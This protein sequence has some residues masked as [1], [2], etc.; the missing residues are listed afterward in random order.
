MNEMIMNP[1]MPVPAQEALTAEP[2]QP[3]LEVVV[4]EMLNKAE[5][6]V[7][8]ISEYVDKPY[9]GQL[10]RM[11]IVPYREEDIAA[12]ADAVWLFRVTNLAFERDKNDFGRKLGN[13][14]S[15]VGMCGGT[16]VMRIDYTQE[17]TVLQIG[18]V[19]KKHETSITT[20]KDALYSSFRSN[21]HGSNLVEVGYDQVCGM[22]KGCEENSYS[23]NSVTSISVMPRRTDKGDMLNGLESILNAAGEQP[24]SILVIG[25]PMDAG[26]KLALKETYEQ[27]ATQ[28]SR[29]ISLS[30]TQQEGSGVSDGVN[31]NLSNAYMH[32]RNITLNVTDSENSSHTESATD[33][34]N[35]NKS[36]RISDKLFSA[37]SLLS[38][39]DGD[40]M[41]V[42]ALNSLKQMTRTQPDRFTDRSSSDTAGTGH[43]VGQGLGET[44]GETLT[45]QQGLSR[46]LT[47]N[48]GYSAQ[49]SVVNHKAKGLYDRVVKYL[50]WLDSSENYGMFNVS[51]YVL[52]SNA[53]TNM[54]IASQ[55]ASM[56]N[57]ENIA[58][59]YGIN[60]WSG[61]ES[62]A[63]RRYLSVFRHPVFSHGDLG[64]VS[65]GVPVSGA[66]LAQSFLLPQKSI[67]SLSVLQYEPFGRNVV[68]T[69]ASGARRAINL[70][71]IHHMG[72][73]IPF[74]PVMLDLETLSRHM[75][76]GGSNGIGKTT[77]ILSMLTKTMKQGIPF[78]VI[79]PAKGEY[80]RVFA[81]DK[82][83]K[84][85][86]LM[87]QKGTRPLRLN[88]FWFREGIDI[89]EHIV[90]LVEV[91]CSCWPMY[92]A[93][94]Q[95][96]QAAIGSAYRACGW[97]LEDSENPNGHIFPNIGDVCREVNSLI[98]QSDFSGE[99]KGNYK[100]SLVTRLKSLDDTVF[101]RIFSC[102]DVGDEELFENNVIIDIS[103]PDSE[104]VKSLIMGLLIVR[105]FEYCAAEK[106]FG[107]TLKHL[108]VL[109]EAHT[110][111]AP[112]PASS[113]GANMGNKAIEMMSRCIAELGGFGQGFII[114]DQAPGLLDRSVIRNTNTKMTFRLL[115]LDDCQLTGK[116][117]GLKDAQCAELARLGRGVCAVHQTGWEEAVLCHVR[118]EL[119][120]K[121][122]DCAGPEEE[123]AAAPTVSDYLTCLL[124]PFSVIGQT[125]AV[126]ADEH[127]AAFDWAAEAGMSAADRLTLIQAIDRA[128]LS[129]RRTVDAVGLLGIA[130]YQGE[131]GDLARWT[132]EALEEMK[133]YLTDRKLALTLIEALLDVEQRKSHDF[134]DF[135]DRWFDAV[136]HERT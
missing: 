1:E 132:E 84:S 81:D 32:S 88:P 62:L 61:E 45:L 123:S 133:P 50:Q 60:T 55:Y 116:A 5:N 125:V 72:G 28:L 63:V 136:K 109:E 79:E 68:S 131:R 110:L 106:D 20:L 70:G 119:P 104:E 36:G 89:N 21:F 49:Y 18:V 75:F 17:D 10:N 99:V 135:H 127:R 105:H 83:V 15:A 113:E 16:M 64:T 2:Q 86:S 12:A 118:P 48:Q 3:R 41:T 90:K 80:R 34:D 71:C 11:K 53:S 57:G 82:R 96:L 43:S 54:S 126:G 128:A 6:A 39:L 66:E 97:I 13:V 40:M 100:G 4:G 114:V 115:D 65:P 26:D 31:Q 38:L 25:D 8:L 76:A 124:K 23:F 74:A 95:V 103:R 67:G 111:L 52:S 69:L 108:T 98:D 130:P 122:E 120:G 56:M 24:F 19:D 51:A 46:T 30:F 22:M 29:F 7:S 134:D 93:M 129:W 107:D 112:K 85:Y 9:Y 73:D 35:P 27:L 37:A 94:P 77:A 59:T 92:A 78:L 42:W 102:G 14:L 87:R 101:R 47:A 44:D 58:R 33:R 117:M 91:F 121:T